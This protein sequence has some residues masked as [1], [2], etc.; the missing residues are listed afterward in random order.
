[1]HFTKIGGG[2]MLALCLAGCNQMGVRGAGGAGIDRTELRVFYGDCLF[3]GESG[4]LLAPVVSSV[5]SNT[6][7][8]F[9]TALRRL[10]EAETYSETDF[11][12]LELSPGSQLNCI[13]VVKG[14]FEGKGDGIEIGEAPRAVKL[15]SQINLSSA[16]DFFIE[17]R[18]R[19]SADAAF[20]TLQPTYLDYRGL[21]KD[22]SS[23][24]N[25]SRSIAMQL[26]FHGA[27]KDADD[28]TA[29][30][31]TVLLGNL[32]VGTTRD[33]A[34]PPDSLD[35]TSA[36]SPWFPTFMP[37]GGPP[38]RN[39]SN[40]APAAP[41]PANPQ[42]DDSTPSSG[43]TKVPMSLTVTVAE[44]RS[45]RPFILFLADVFDDT[46]EDVK[47]QLE[48]M[49][50]SEKRQQARDAAEAASQQALIDYNGKFATAETK[51]IDYCA[52]PADDNSDSAKKAR[53]EVSN[54]LFAAQVAANLT[55]R[56][57]GLAVPYPDVVEVS[58]GPPS[59][60]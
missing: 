2:V 41:Q 51:R 56:A 3:S 48:L 34:V 50:L 11:R 12:N 21:L 29:V 9:G 26:S 33:Y 25:A 27:G 22:G 7:D 58:T 10:G 49:L 53:L 44:T 24:A 59:G 46:K 30:G 40:A 57:A 6:L 18:P 45:E 32:R 35:V 16:P 4:A 28:N 60:C 5:L 13:Q 14:T 20:L 31:T 15:P 37:A 1:M 54:A 17:L 19:T 43:G 36:E 23:P 39:A 55:A 52:L 47:T 8:R 42:P 38:K